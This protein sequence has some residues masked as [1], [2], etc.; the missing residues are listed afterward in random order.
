MITMVDKVYTIYI[1]IYSSW[2]VW[3]LKTRPICYPD[4]SVPNNQPMPRNTFS[5]ES[6]SFKYE[7][8]EL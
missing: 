2:A 4:T 1:N 3:P 7:V 6:E 8:V 5:Q